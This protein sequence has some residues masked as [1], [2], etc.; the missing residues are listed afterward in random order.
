MNICLNPYSNG[1]LTWNDNLDLDTIDSYSVLI[2]ILME[3]SL[4]LMS[5]FAWMLCA[6]LNPYSNGMLTWIIG[7]KNTSLAERVLILILMECSL[8]V[9]KRKYSLV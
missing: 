7:Q 8:G 6:C 1:M 9:S 2:L 3:C 4:G 5:A